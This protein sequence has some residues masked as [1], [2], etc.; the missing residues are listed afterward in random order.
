MP[1]DK[2]TLSLSRADAEVLLGVVSAERHNADADAVCDTIRKQ[3]D[4]QLA[5]PA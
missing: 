4:E 3:I 2:I 5:N 1:E